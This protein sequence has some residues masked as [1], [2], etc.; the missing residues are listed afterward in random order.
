MNYGDI[1]QAIYIVNK[2]AKTAL[3]SS[4][5]YGLKSSAINKL[6]E[7]GAAKKVGLHFSPN[8]KL[9][10]QRVDVIIE[11]E[12][13]IF[14]IPP[15]KSDRNNLPNLG[16]RDEEYRNPKSNFSI[17][18]SKEILELYINKKPTVS[19]KSKTPSSKIQNSIFLSSYLGGKK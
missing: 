10:K 9:C 6:L 2:H 7:E 11:V 14:H 3:D 19:P 1:A 17:K 12:N 4:Y 15:S 16:D 8:P 5:L 18:K 13:F